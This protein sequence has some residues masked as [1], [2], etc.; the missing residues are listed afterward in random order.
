[1]SRIPGGYSVRLGVVVKVYNTQVEVQYTD[2]QFERNV[3]CPIP[4]PHAGVGSGI[5]MGVEKG[6]RVLISHGPQEIPYIVAVLPERSYYF[7]QSGVENSSTDLT[8]YPSVVSGEICLKGPE[9]ST[10]FMTRDGNI[11]LD[12]GAGDLGADL[13][14]SN[15]SQA[16]YT[17]TNNFYKFTE[18]GREIEGVVRR[19][20]GDTEDPNDTSTLN[21]LSGEEYDGILV[22]IGRS[23]ADEV[24]LRSSTISKLTIRNPALVEKKNITYEFADSF[25]VRDIVNEAAS[26]TV[27]N[28]SNSNIVTSSLAVDVSTRE[29]RRTDTL[30]LNLRNFNHLIEKVEGTVVDIYGKVLDINRNIINIP[31]VESLNSKAS[32]EQGLLRT[33]SYLRR[34]IKYHFEINSR[35]DIRDID[36]PLHKTSYN[37]TEHGRWSVDIDG[38]GLTK[39]NIPA[40]SETGNIPV[41]GRYITS[42]ILN[43]VGSQGQFKDKNKRDIRL[44][45]FGSS[46]PNAPDVFIGPTIDGSD[47]H[48]LSVDNNPVT[49]DCTAHHDILSIASSIFTSGKLKNPD[50]AVDAYVGPVS[51]TINNNILSLQSDGTYQTN[52][53]AN[54]GGRSAHVNMDGSAE[55]FIGAD[56]LDRKSLLIDFAGGVIS[57][58]G[59]DING[60]SLIH[61]TDG[62]VIIQI[63][64][65]GI[66]GD[67]RFKKPVDTENR[68]GR[69]EI[70]LNRPNGT[71]QMILIDEKGMTLNIQGDIVMSSTGNFAISAG[72]QLLLNGEVVNIYGAANTEI[73]G[74]R[75]IIGSERHVDRIGYPIK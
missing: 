67:D 21:F 74:D 28:S 8:S 52:P 23:T 55:I 51:L 56:S 45:P 36:P 11:A 69:I 17:R 40:S 62:D 1:M 12:G 16:L 22:G 54:A 57:H 59:R 10:L 27:V 37:A 39:I 73:S 38:E 15:F 64:G 30:N 60:R 25:G 13:E 33:Y 5:F 2:R 43:G 35:K 4:H 63:G 70:H 66:S 24:S 53:D 18:A 65:K 68:P 7:D 14:L 61:Q 19:D 41:L 47:Y 75:S 31:E 48:P 58:Y 34:S 9:S 26:T 46:E 72:G 42:N 6:T 29:N 32:V 44:I 3:R 49:T 50:P 20:V 71:S